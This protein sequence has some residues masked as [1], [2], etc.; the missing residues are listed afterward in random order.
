MRLSSSFWSCLAAVLSDFFW[1]AL[2]AARSSARLAEARRVAFSDLRV[3]FYCG[4]RFAR[5]S[6]ASCAGF[7]MRKEWL[8]RV[9]RGIKFPSAHI[10]LQITE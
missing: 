3:A 10:R 7:F 1:L 2:L 5:F 6:G 9:R 4:V 8:I